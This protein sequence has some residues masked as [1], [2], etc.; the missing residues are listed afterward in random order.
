[1]NATAMLSLVGAV[2]LYTAG[3]ASAA[4]TNPTHMSAVSR[5]ALEHNCADAKA[6]Y[7]AGDPEITTQCDEGDQ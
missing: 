5:Q 3:A 2:L 4:E 7:S 6:R 1:M